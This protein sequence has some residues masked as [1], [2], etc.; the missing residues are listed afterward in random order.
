MLLSGLHILYVCKTNKYKFC[1]IVAVIVLALS[2]VVVVA[3]SLIK[4]LSVIN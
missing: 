1:N 2:I 4:R 3:V